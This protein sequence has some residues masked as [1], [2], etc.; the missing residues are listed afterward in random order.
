MHSLPPTML[1][2]AQSS[3]AFVMLAHTTVHFWVHV[4]HSLVW[5]DALRSAI[6]AR[7]YSAD[8][9]PAS[10]SRDRKNSNSL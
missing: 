5:H 6:C 9:V 3:T 1:L 8:G 10:A 7:P 2:N 4:E